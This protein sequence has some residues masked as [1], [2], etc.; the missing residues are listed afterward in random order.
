MFDRLAPP[1]PKTG[2]C[3]CGSGHFGYALYD[4]RQQFVLYGCHACERKQ[5]SV[6]EK[7][8]SPTREV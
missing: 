1:D 5:R 3:S 2:L 6:A 4:T 7:P 8:Q